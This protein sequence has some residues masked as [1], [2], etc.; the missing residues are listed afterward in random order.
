MNTTT[1]SLIGE[2]CFIIYMG[3]HNSLCYW[4]G[5]LLKLLIINKLYTSV[6]HK[7]DGVST[8]LEYKQHFQTAI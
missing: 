4:V 7:I 2:S 8:V 3:G 1:L 6:E 5:T